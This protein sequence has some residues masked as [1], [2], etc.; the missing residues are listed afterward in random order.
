MASAGYYRNEAKRCRDLAASAADGET[1]K[2]WHRLADEYGVLAEEFDRAET[3]RPAILR[4][5]M[6][7]QPVQ[8]QQSKSEPEDNDKKPED[9]DA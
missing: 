8:Q 2:R 9:R 5:P 1:A 3:G 4:T 7:R 6:Q